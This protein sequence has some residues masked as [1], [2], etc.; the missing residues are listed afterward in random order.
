MNA[1]ILSTRS[2][3]VTLVSP[4]EEVAGEEAAEAFLTRLGQGLTLVHISDQP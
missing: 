4:L 3:L 1:V 2:Y